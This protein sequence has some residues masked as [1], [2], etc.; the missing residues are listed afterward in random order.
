VR[1]AWCYGVLG[2]ARAL[3][4]AGQA[5][6]CAEWTRLGL[7]AARGAVAAMDQSVVRDFS[8]CHG[9]AGI[10]RIVDRMAADS[11]D[12]AL[13][14]AVDPLAGKLLSGFTSDAPFGYRYAPATFPVGGDRPGYLEG[15]AGIALALHAVATGEQPAAD[16]GLLIA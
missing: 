16:A 14:D 8:L 11:G 4:L 10:V 12:P 13:T 6:D 5:L 3:Q 2:I 7:D 9:W 15:A 1:D